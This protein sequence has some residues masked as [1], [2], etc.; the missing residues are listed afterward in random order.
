MKQMSHEIPGNVYCLRFEFQSPLDNLHAVD[1]NLLCKQSLKNI[2][3]IVTKKL[4]ADAT[5][6]M[7]S[8]SLS[9]KR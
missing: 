2:T 1:D 6:M 3:K 8:E 7:I 4:I 5:T 9:Q